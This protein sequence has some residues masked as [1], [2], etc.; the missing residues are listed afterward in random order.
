MKSVRIPLILIVLMVLTWTQAKGESQMIADGSTV[1]I[2][3]VLT[4][5]GQMV[6]S[7]EGKEPL[8]YTQGSGQLIPGLEKQLVGL[9]AGDKK[10]ITVA[11]E[12]AY[13]LIDEKMVV[14]LPKDKLAPGLTP[15]KGMVL[16]L[17][18]K[19]GRTLQGMIVDIKEDALIM[20]FNHPLAGKEL[21]FDIEVV[22]V[23]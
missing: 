1:K 22:D 16:Q 18:T 12:D 21:D 6:D 19:D 10:N 7:S 8:E 4:V 15:E 3:Y 5:D 14:E 11:P 2:N 13:G 23:K 9:K 20:N 17:P